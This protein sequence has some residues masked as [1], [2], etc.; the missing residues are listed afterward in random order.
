MHELTQ[1][2]RQQHDLAFAQMLLCVRTGSH[3]GNDIKMLES[4][5]IDTDDP[6]Y[7]HDALHLFSR[8]RDVDEHNNKRLEALAP[9]ER[10]V[11]IAAIDGKRDHSETIDVTRFTAKS[12]RSDTGGLHSVLTIAVGARVMMTANVATSEGLCNGCIGTVEE[13]IQDQSQKVQVI[14]VKFDDAQVGEKAI[15]ES[16]YR[17]KFPNAVPVNLRKPKMRMSIARNSH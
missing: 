6:T 14:L 5:V 13:I 11:S 10:R 7:P 9:A 12:K 3:T 8:N 17:E 16:P 4:C 15:Q 2:M 1:S